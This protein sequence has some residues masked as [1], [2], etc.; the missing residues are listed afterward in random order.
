MT[1]NRKLATLIL[2]VVA[3][4]LTLMPTR[5]HAQCD[6]TTIVGSYGYELSVF[7]APSAPPRVG[8]FFPTSAFAPGRLR[9]ESCLRLLLP[10]FRDLEWAMSGVCPRPPRS[11]D[12]I[13]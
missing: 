4:C 8:G 2:L 10:A 9:V 6:A 13:P 5:A 3:M 12:R 7:F 11:P 1:Y